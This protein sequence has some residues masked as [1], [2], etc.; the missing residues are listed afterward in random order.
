M[1]P[2][3]TLLALALAALAIPAHADFSG[4]YAPANWITA[5]TGTLTGSGTTVGS[6]TFS[7]SLL[8]L[9]GGNG[10]APAGSDA[11]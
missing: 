7:S 2:L 5:S 10:I 3:S 6:A 11:S 1:K 9:V 8:T 4:P